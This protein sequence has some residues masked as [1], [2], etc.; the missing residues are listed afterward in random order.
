MSNP[1]PEVLDLMLP[2]SLVDNTVGKRPAHL[3]E[4]MRIWVRPMTKFTQKKAT[5]PQYSH[6]LC[7]IPL[8]DSALVS[9]WLE[10]TF[11]PFHFQE[12]RKTCTC[13]FAQD[14]LRCPTDVGVKLLLTWIYRALRCLTCCHPRNNLNALIFHHKLQIILVMLTNL[15]NLGTPWEMSPWELRAVF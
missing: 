10:K 7:R 8:R 4:L 1:S 3:G 12:E 13:G 11:I 14:R 5:P 6:T 2:P 9:S 15:V